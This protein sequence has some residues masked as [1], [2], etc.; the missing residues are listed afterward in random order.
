MRKRSRGKKKLLNRKL[1]IIAGIAGLFLLIIGIGIGSLVTTRGLLEIRIDN[2]PIG[3]DFRGN[4][5]S[6]S[7][8][9]VWIS[10]IAAGSKIEQYIY[11]E[12][13]GKEDVE[14]TTFASV[15]WVSFDN[16]KIEVTANSTTKVC[17]FIDIPPDFNTKDKSFE[18]L[19]GV[20]KDSPSVNVI[21]CAR[22]FLDIK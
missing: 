4:N 1:L 13:K 6:L 19:A 16:N 3:I 15:K 8:S 10:N 21:T 2:S 12:N 20:K 7:P 14:L 17:V 11:V 9:K 5:I 22:Y 18:F